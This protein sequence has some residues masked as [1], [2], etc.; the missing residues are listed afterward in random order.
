MCCTIISEFDSVNDTA[1]VSL[2]MEQKRLKNP[3]ALAAS[4]NLK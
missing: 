1:V 2:V 3:V 4:M